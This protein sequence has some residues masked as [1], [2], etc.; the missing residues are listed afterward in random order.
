MVYY[1]F[2]HAEGAGITLNSNKPEHQL[3]YGKVRPRS[4]LESFETAV[5]GLNSSQSKV[6]CKQELKGVLGE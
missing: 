4:A 3:C 6:L 1:G 2:G 5:Q